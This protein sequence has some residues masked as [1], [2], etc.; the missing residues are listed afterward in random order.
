MPARRGLKVIAAVLNCRIGDRAVRHLDVAAMFASLWLLA[1]MIIDAVTPKELTVYMIGAATAPAFLILAFAYWRKYP[2][3]DF[4]ILVAT[5]WLITLMVLE[6]ITPK[7]LSLMM[8]AIAIAPAVIV[9]CV[10]NYGRWRSSRR[11]RPRPAQ[12]SS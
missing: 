3:L 8:A 9:G 5:L 12:P 11:D 10:I 4:G 1:S 7:P 6:F 2:K